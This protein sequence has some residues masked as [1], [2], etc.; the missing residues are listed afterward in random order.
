MSGA[1]RQEGNVH[2]PP[3]DFKK[4]VDDF[5]CALKRVCGYAFDETHLRTVTSSVAHP[6]QSERLEGIGDLTGVSQV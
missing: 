3:P 1:N 6:G 4:L 2:R 5:V